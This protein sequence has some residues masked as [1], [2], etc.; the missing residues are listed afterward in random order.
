MRFNKRLFVT[1]PIA[2]ILVSLLLGVTSMP[3]VSVAETA[4]SRETS[5]T[6]V[7]FTP[8]AAQPM[9]SVAV[10]SKDGQAASS[11]TGVPAYQSA[12]YA[13]PAALDAITPA[14]N[15][16]GD[17]YEVDGTKA[18][19]K[20]ITTD[21]SVQEHSFHVIVDEDW[22]T[23]D[24]V[25]GATYFIETREGS[26]G[27]DTEM[28]LYDADLT[29]LAESDNDSDLY[30]YCSYIEYNAVADETLFLLVHSSGH[31]QVGS[32]LLL[33]SSS[34]S[35]SYEPDD[36]PAQA[37]P[38]VIDAAPQVHSYHVASD[39]DWV[40]FEA[41]AGVTYRIE[42]L[43]G[44]YID[45]YLYLYDADL[46]EI[47]SDD[48]HGVQAFSLIVYTATADETLY[49][50]SHSSAHYD[51]GFYQ[52]QVTSRDTADAFE[53]DDSPATASA[54]ATTGAMQARTFH[55]VDDD[56][57]VSFEA[58]A[59]VTYYLET[60]EGSVGIDTVIDLYDA[61]LVRLDGDDDG[62]QW[63]QYCSYLE[64][65]ATAN[66]TLHIRIHPYYY[67]E[68]GSY[69]LLVSASTPDAYEPDDVHAEANSIAIDG[70]PQERTFHVA[71]DED[72]VTFEAVAGL[73][74]SIDTWPGTDQDTEL[75]LFD[76]D[77]NEIGYDDDSGPRAF[78]HIEF[79]ATVSGPVYVLVNS[80]GGAWTG[81]YRLTVDCSD[82]VP[83]VTTSD[84]AASYTNS[85]SITL[86]ASDPAPGVGVEVTYYALDGGVEQTYVGPITVV[87]AGSHTLSYWSID[88]ATNDET[89]KTAAFTV[90]VPAP[91]APA[92]SGTAP[93][94]STTTVAAASTAST[95]P[96]TSVEPAPTSEPAEVVSADD[97]AE[98]EEQVA[99]DDAD[100][101]E[102]PDDEDGSPM[103][104]IIGGIGGL[105]L[106]GLLAALLRRAKNK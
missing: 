27:V 92:K 40:S 71:T 36:A 33:V 7:P 42:T 21:G 86:A 55:V 70:T 67:D 3:A 78:S 94:T 58:K 8:E 46:N 56:D 88:R 2:L 44:S 66:A 75:T 85:A 26:S 59:G 76:A 83:P 80:L 64:Y 53:P 9:A 41:K 48:D 82:M 49:V 1:R 52:L 34:H 103:W 101:T 31:V 47:T 68:V 18:T 99:G 65:T 37:R 104:W 97:E 22:V 12:T 35:D 69:L 81:A 79:T 87:A 106:I 23:F 73:D 105:A 95:T 100:D 25:A 77:F 54:I 11:I 5:G 74:Y 98:A 72:W 51:V 4:G 50:L 13:P 62:S 96:T 29:E 93:R 28:Y 30:D 60:R 6:T 63:Y 14:A 19:A 89:P 10:P 61:D 17:A 38:I 16:F 39:D 91:V 57:W 84:A 90:G 15:L 20:A 24:V 32:Y 45:T 102:E 43:P